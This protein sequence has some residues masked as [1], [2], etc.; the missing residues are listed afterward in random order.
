MTTTI[1]LLL[2]LAAFVVVPLALSTFRPDDALASRL[3]R[4]AQIA[5]IP[6]AVAVGIA[7]LL[8]RG[9]ASGLVMSVWLVPAA[10]AAVAGLRVLIVQRPLRISGL[11]MVAAVAYFGIG[12]L[13]LVSYAFDLHPFGFPSLIVELTAIHYHYTGLGATMIA[14][15]AV[16]A[17]SEGTTARRVTAVFGLAIAAATPVIAAGITILQITGVTAASAGEFLGAAMLTISLPVIAISS[18]RSA[19]GGPMGARALFGV[20]TVAVCLAMALAV[21]YA[22]GRWLGT[23]APTI[24]TMARVHGPLNALGFTI[25]GLLG[26]RAMRRSGTAA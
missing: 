6:C 13:A 25:F 3:L 18:L 19:R 11:L 12:A 16:A 8:P 20:A 7:F 24:E 26:W 9:W 2:V 17:T 22:A 21:T 14:A 10:A 23:S 4:F 15:C 5:A 1:S